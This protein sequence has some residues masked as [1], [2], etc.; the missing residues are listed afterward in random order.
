LSSTPDT[1]QLLA[2]R[3]RLLQSLG[4]GGF[5]DTYLATDEQL[6]S[7]RQVVVKRLRPLKDDEP[8]RDAVT[9]AFRREAR[10]LE[11]VGRDHD[12]IP[13]LFAYFEED[14]AYWLVQEFVP[15]ATLESLGRISSETAR[16]L[17]AD[18][19]PVLTF[20]HS[21][22]L[23]HRDI[24]PDNIMLREGDRRPVLI[25]FGAVRETMSTVVL[26][27]GAS[28]SSLVIGTQGYMPPEQ[29]AGRPI[30]SSDLYALALT[31]IT[32]LTGRSPQELPSDPV[33]GAVLWRSEVPGVDPTLA[34][35]LDRAIQPIPAQRFPSAQVMLEAL[36]AGSPAAA[37]PPVAPAAVAATQATVVVAPQQQPYTATPQMP[38][39]APPA[40]PSGYVPPP[41]PAASGSNSM[42]AIALSGFGLIVAVALG[43]GALFISQQNQQQAQLAAARQEASLR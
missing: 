27:T 31:L 36:G 23:L 24:K 40:A 3:Y 35:V 7:G 16:Q 28:A 21:R 33:S 15:G 4:S 6:P 20:L 30:F 19:L 12:Q 34:E 1:N 42:V 14:G 11:R 39:Q 26:A 38:P 8:S 18:L 13:E 41:A 37:V 22:N 9:A 5:G 17:L 25:D 2:G 32:L 43:L 29:A 10:L